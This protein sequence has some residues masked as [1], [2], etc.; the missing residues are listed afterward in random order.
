[1]VYFSLILRVGH[2]WDKFGTNKG[3]LGQNGEWDM[4]HFPYRECPSHFHCFSDVPFDRQPDALFVTFTNPTRC[5]E[6]VPSPLK[7]LPLG[8]GTL[9][10]E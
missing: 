6:L 3:H 8:I 7:V 4:G 1:M 5:L 9:A 2:F 10:L